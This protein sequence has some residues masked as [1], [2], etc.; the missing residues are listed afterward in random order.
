M[1]IEHFIHERPS[2]DEAVRLLDCTDWRS[3]AAVAGPIRDSLWGSQLTYSRKVFIPLTHLCRDVCHYCTFAKTPRNLLQPYLSPDD[4]L[5]IAKRGAA[6]GC[7]EA[8]F[9]LGDKPELRYA[10]ARQALTTLGFESTL[11]YLEHVAALVLRETGLLPH[12]NP[13]LLNSPNFERLR[14]V[15]P[16]MGFMLETASDRLSE[17]GGPHFGS[18]DKLPARRIETLQRAGEARIPTTSGILIGIG[19]T[20]LERIQAL[21]VLR[22][23]SDRY[24]HLQEVI[25]QNFRAKPGTKMHAA[26]EPSMDDLCWTVAV[27]RLIFGPSMSL[28]VPPNLFGGDL[29]DLVRAGINDWGGVSPVTPDHVNPEAP[30]P[31]LDFL[32]SES[33]RAGYN[34]VERLTV[35]PQYIAARQQWIAPEVAPHV[36]RLSDG[37]NLARPGRWASGSNEDVNADDLRDIARP[38][39]TTTLFAALL[40]KILSGAE[41]TESETALLFTARGSDFTRV[42]D[43]ADRLRQAAAGEVVSYAVVRNISKQ[44]KG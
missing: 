20:R 12:L 8:L 25:I 10:K 37:A 2:A 30:W 19:E 3:L 40:D 7:K 14:R 32:A 28:Q 6:V 24:G 5:D 29:T 4:V 16:S 27:A 13:G 41:A 38:R 42:C 33:E 11:A 22:D 21:L 34:L 1:N 39:R 18:P 35:Y 44:S 31:N 9:T 26:A 17:R 36:L 23:L 43:A 15:A